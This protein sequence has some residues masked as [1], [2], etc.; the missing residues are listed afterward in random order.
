MKTI[1]KLRL[2][3]TR[4]GILLSCKRKSK[5]LPQIMGGDLCVWKEKRNQIAKLW[6]QR[7]IKSLMPRYEM[8]RRKRLCHTNEPI[9]FLLLF[10]EGGNRI[11]QSI[12]IV[13]HM[14]V[15]RRYV[16]VQLLIRLSC[17]WRWMYDTHDGFS[18]CWCHVG[19]V[20]IVEARK[21]CV[22]WVMGWQGV[23]ALVGILWFHVHSHLRSILPPV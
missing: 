3:N 6:Q 23:V 20:D 11:A 9:F 16:E 18:T 7:K 8:T 2:L 5:R 12:Q 17:C 22:R 21:S 1:W 14:R 19:V 13:V 4:N 10:R 15:L